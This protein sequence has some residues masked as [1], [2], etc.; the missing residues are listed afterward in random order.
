MNL[1]FKSIDDVSWSIIKPY[2]ANYEMSDANDTLRLITKGISSEL[3]IVADSVK[4]LPKNANLHQ[5]PLSHPKS[6]I[7]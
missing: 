6:I 3:L 7:E 5:T 1:S 2:C 4:L